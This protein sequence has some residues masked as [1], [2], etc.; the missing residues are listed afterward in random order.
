MR[1]LASICARVCALSGVL[2]LASC[3]ASSGQLGTAA[4]SIAPPPATARLVI[5]R[6]SIFGLALQPDYTLNG[7][8]IGLSQAKGF[9]LCDV[10]PGKYELVTPNPD[11]NVNLGGGTNKLELNLA[12]GTTTYIEATASMG[13][14]VGVIVLQTAAAERGRSETADLHQTP[15]TCP[16]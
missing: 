16:V 4:L 5:F 11:M 9:I 13:L 1:I 15:S 6:N 12:A 8:K 3:A 14:V 7:S 10:K 2:I